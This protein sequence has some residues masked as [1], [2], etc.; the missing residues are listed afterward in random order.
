MSSIACTF[1]LSLPLPT[2]P[3]S[4]LSVPLVFD[5]LE[6]G[7]GSGSHKT[8]CG[9]AGLHMLTCLTDLLLLLCD[10]CL[11]DSVVPPGRAPLLLDYLYSTLAH[12]YYYYYYYYD[13]FSFLFLFYFSFFA[14]KRLNWCSCF[15]WGVCSVHFSWR[16]ACDLSRW[17]LCL[18]K[19]YFI[20]VRRRRRKKPF[21]LSFQNVLMLANTPTPW[22]W[23]AIIL[24]SI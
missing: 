10:K 20:N 16:D 19:M 6:L 18:H 12:Y 5:P 9:S 7:R 23:S 11:L 17:L 21:W 24:I 1:S 8:Q 13:M 15:P 14:S 22:F 3:H 4:I 2:H